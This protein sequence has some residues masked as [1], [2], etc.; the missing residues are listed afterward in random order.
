MRDG[1]YGVGILFILLTVGATTYIGIGTQNVHLPAVVLQLILAIVWAIG[2]SLAYLSFR[3]PR[4]V[5]AIGMASLAY[6]AERAV[7]HH[8]RQDA[9]IYAHELQRASES[10]ISAI[11]GR[12][13]RAAR[14]QPLKS[15]VYNVAGNWLPSVECS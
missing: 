4:T 10:S 2:G 3:A 8:V 11:D 1:G 6:R 13:L 5:N 9:R 14:T 7:H 12:Q 15:V